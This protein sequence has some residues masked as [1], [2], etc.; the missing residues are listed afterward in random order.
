M[1]S[2]SLSG[3]GTFRYRN[4]DQARTLNVEASCEHEHF[5][6]NREL[7]CSIYSP[8][9]CSPTVSVHST[10]CTLPPIPSDSFH[11]ASQPSISFHHRNNATPIPRQEHCTTRSPGPYRNGRFRLRSPPFR[12]HLSGLSLPS[13]PRAS[14]LQ[15]IDGTIQGVYTV[16]CDDV[17]RMYLCGEEG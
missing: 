6:L 3:V 1:T 16:I 8:A 17:G 11:V 7:D 14:H 5:E 2:A 12:G 9:N 10:P 15:R 13:E 4:S